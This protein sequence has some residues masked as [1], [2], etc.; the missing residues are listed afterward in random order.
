VAIEY[1]WAQGQYERLPGLTADLVGRQVAVIAATGGP[2]SGLAAKAATSPIPIVFISGSDPVNAGLVGSLNRPEAN[3]TGVTFFADELMAKRLELLR[4]LVPNAATVAVLLNP[5][6]VDTPGELRDV[7]AA[8]RET[9]Q[10]LLVLSASTE[11]EI[12]VAFA[13]VKRAADALIV[14]GD[15]FFS[16]RRDQLSALMEHYA[17]PTISF[18]RDVSAP[19]AQITYGPRLADAYRQVGVYTGRILKGAKPADLPVVR[20]T[21]FELIINLKSI[22]AIGLMVPPSLLLR[23]DEVIE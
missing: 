21:K 13:T 1:R 11:S 15:P 8:A 22:K 10:R 17:I 12:D 18:S 5:G 7:Q 4:E 16:S 9:G 2:A 3:L 6:N 20:P 14:G 19:Y 23:A